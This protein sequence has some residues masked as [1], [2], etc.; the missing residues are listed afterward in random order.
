MNFNGINQDATTGT[1]MS[2]P[3]SFSLAVW[4]NATT[5][6]GKKLIGMENPGTG[7]AF[8]TNFDRLLWVGT[9][10]KLYFGHYTGVSTKSVYHISSPLRVFDGVPH[11]AVGTFD[12]SS[13]KLYVD[14]D[15]VASQTTTG[16]AEVY[17][18]RWRIGGYWMDA[19]WTSL[20][21]ASNGFVSARIIAVQA[22]STALSAQQVL[23]NYAA[24]MTN[25]SLIPS[26]AMNYPCSAGMCAFC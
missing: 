21:G 15:L 6:S 22:Y 7:T 12:A 3:T 10:G 20:G 24:L 9:D 1:S 17:T 26:T 13:F 23:S 16:S 4:F 14:G 8:P 25:G 5:A 11:Y 2:A 19:G 18:G